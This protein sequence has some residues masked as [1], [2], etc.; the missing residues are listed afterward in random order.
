MGW[1]MN[2]C[3]FEGERHGWDFDKRGVWFQGSFMRGAW[4]W[5]NEGW[6]WFQGSSGWDLIR[7]KCGFT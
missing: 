6:A 4:A 5:R 1:C 7:G 2:G 3:S